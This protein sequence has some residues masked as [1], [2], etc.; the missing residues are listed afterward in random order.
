MH[1]P[2][3]WEDAIFALIFSGQLSAEIIGDGAVI[4]RRVLKGTDS[5]VKATR[6]IKATG[7]GRHLCQNAFVATDIDDDRH[8]GVIFRCRSHHCWAADIDIFNRI[9][10]V[11]IGLGNRLLEGVKVDYHHVDGANAVFVH[12]RIIGAASA[13]NTAVDFGVKGLNPPVHHFRETGVIRHFDSL[14]I[15]FN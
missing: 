15:I 12:H 8:I 6:L 4:G 11:A 9:K 2:G 5:E 14:N 1:I 13:Q 3:A 10:Q 7:I